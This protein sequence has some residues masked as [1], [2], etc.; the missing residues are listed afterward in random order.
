MIFF[1]KS[2]KSGVAGKRK[3]NYL[4]YYRKERCSLREKRNNASF[5]SKK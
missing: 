1:I 4:Y 3:D 2:N 5:R